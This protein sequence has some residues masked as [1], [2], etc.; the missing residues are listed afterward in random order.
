MNTETSTTVNFQESLYGKQEIVLPAVEEKVLFALSGDSL[1]SQCYLPVKMVK[2]QFITAGKKS[3]VVQIREKRPEAPVTAELGGLIP[4]AMF[5]LIIL[6]KV[7]YPRRFYQMITASFSNNA[8]WQLLREWYPLNNGLTYLYTT[9]YYL[10]FALLISS[11]GTAIGGGISITGKWLPDILILFGG[12]AFIISGK[13]VTIMSLAVIFNSRDSGE[14]YLTNQITFSL[15]SV[16]FLIPVLLLLHF[17]P[18][19]LSLIGSLV[20]LGFVQTVRI[21]R[22]MR[23]GLTE[24]SFGL[25]YLFLY[26]CALEI[27]PLLILIKSFL[28]LSKGEAFG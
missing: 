16:L 10:G 22:S 14:R 7:L 13:Y 12:V 19:E 21:I 4:F 28:L 26:L 23:V 24:K 6:T 9:L 2:K 18:N 27:V 8:Q 17:Q 3:A 1:T 15:I 20:L 25:I 5:G 11:I